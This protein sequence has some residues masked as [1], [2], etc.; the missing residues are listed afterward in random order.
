MI[1]DVLQLPVWAVVGATDNPQK[2]G[3]KIYKFMKASGYEVFPVNPGVK[4]LDGETCYPSLAAL[5]KKP[6][7]VDVVVPPR[8][9]EQVLR[10][11]AQAG[12]KYVW[13]QPGAESDALIALGEQLGLNV[14]HHD[15]I[16]TAIRS[17][18]G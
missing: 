5:P 4:T 1:Q 16:M 14:I 10:D 12:I 3:C 13:L 11:A 18:K 2:F 7:A 15:C 17:R 9:G 6:D 8:V